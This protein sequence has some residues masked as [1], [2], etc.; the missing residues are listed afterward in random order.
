MEGGG[1]KCRNEGLKE[2]VGTRAR[3]QGGKGARRKEEGRKEGGNGLMKE[4]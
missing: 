2:G 3:G 1:V 4:V